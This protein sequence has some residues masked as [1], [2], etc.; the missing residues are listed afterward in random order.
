SGNSVEVTI[1]EGV[2]RQQ[3]LAQL[4]E[5]TH[6][7]GSKPGA[8]IERFTITEAGG[9][10]LRLAPTQA[11]INDGVARAHDRTMAVLGRR[12]DG[13]GLTPTLPPR[14]CPH[15]GDRGSPSAGSPPPQGG[16]RYARQ[17]RIPPGRPL[18]ERPG[19]GD[20]PGTVR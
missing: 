12:L 16:Y 7:P 1:R 17:A 9:A 20:G 11:A 4:R 14:W 2:D 19:D 18:G 5:L 6:R 15:D 13:L 8:E 10:L 3:A